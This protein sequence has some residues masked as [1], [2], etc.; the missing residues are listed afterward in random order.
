MGRT[1]ILSKLQ[2]LYIEKDEYYEGTGGNVETHEIWQK[3]KRGYRLERLLGPTKKD[4]GKQPGG[5]IALLLSTLRD[6]VCRLVTCGPY[7]SDVSNASSQATL[8]IR[9]LL[10]VS[11]ALPEGLERH[12]LCSIM[13]DVLEYTRTLFSRKK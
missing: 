11:G 12:V 6:F 5:R 9:R 3:V 7:C 8:K 4:K 2:G 10:W 13:T 1:T